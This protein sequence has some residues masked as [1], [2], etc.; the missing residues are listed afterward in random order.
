MS[1]PGGSLE[2]GRNWFFSRIVIIIPQLTVKAF[3]GE[4][5]GETDDIPGNREE[6]AA[7]YAPKPPTRKQRSTVNNLR[8]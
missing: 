6:R 3:R 8:K 1:F 7:A 4:R 5:A 2:K